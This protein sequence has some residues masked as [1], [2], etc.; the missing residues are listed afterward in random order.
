M[1]RIRVGRRCGRRAR[2]RTRRRAARTAAER[3]IVNVAAGTSGTDAVNLNQM[4]S[5]L[6]QQSTAFNQQI[7]G[8]QNSI[9][10]V[11]KNA[12]AG[13]AAAMAMPNLTPSGPGRTVV[14]AGGGYY[15]GSSAAAVG[16]TYRSSNMH[17]LVNG[18]VSVTDNGDAGARAQIGYEF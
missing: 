5:A 10:T 17:W 4:N 13:V 6:S 8:L 3:Q 12:Y 7:S 11:E 15:K 9:N 2:G 1:H 14:A 16:V 18:A